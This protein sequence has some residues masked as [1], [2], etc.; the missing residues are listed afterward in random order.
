MLAAVQ[1]SIRHPSTP[2]LANLHSNGIQIDSFY[3]FYVDV[4]LH[5]QRQHAWCVRRIARP[6]PEQF[7]S[8]CDPTSLSLPH[9][10]NAFHAL[11]FSLEPSFLAQLVAIQ[12]DWSINNAL[13]ISDRCQWFQCDLQPMHRIQHFFEMIAGQIYPVLSFSRESE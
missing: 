13:S 4:N 12:N 1:P 6:V 7:K 9:Q 10:T 5:V 8:S 11:F 2:T 3:H